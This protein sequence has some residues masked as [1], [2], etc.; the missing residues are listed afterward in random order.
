MTP[1]RQLRYRTSANSSSVP[2]SGDAEVVIGITAFTMAGALPPMS[3]RLGRAGVAGRPAGGIPALTF[4]AYATARV[5]SVQMLG[6]GMAVAV[7]VGATVTRA[8]LVPSLMR[9]AGPLNWWPAGRTTTS[10]R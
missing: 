2:R 9:L 3:G 1:P 4:A 10:G 5:S 8:V 7:L 6:V